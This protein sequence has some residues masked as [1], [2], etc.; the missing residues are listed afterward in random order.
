MIMINCRCQV[1][2]VVGSKSLVHLRQVFRE[3]EKERRSGAMIVH[4]VV[5]WSA[6]GGR[7]V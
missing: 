6:R 2:Q 3:D 7:V 5:W 4:M 1:L